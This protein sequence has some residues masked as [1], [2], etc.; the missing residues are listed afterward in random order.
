MLVLG[1]CLLRLLKMLQSVA[2]CAAAKATARDIRKY[3]GRWRREKSSDV[4]GDLGVI[5]EKCANVKTDIKKA[6][7]EVVALWRPK[8]ATP[9]SFN[10]SDF[11][12]LTRFL[13]FMGAGGVGRYGRTH[14]ICQ[15]TANADALF[16][17]A[18][19][20]NDNFFNFLES[21]LDVGELCRGPVKKPDRA[22]QKVAR[23]YYY[24][25]RHLTDLVRCCV[26]CEYIRDVRRLLDQIFELCSIFGEEASGNVERNDTQNEDE[27]ALLGGGHDGNSQPTFT[28]G[29]KWKNVG[30]IKPEG[31]RELSNFK[32][33][34]AL[35]LKREFT[36]DEWIEFGV[37]DLGEEDF[38]KSGSSY[39]KPAAKVF[40]LC[41]I[42][43]DFT[44]EGLGYRFIC[45][46]LEVGWTIES[47]SGDK[48]QFVTVKDFDKQHVRTHIC[49]VQILL[50]STYELLKIG[51]CHGNFIKARNMLSQ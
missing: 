2:K 16:E 45:L 22:F 47:E 1:L 12:L 15:V 34:T 46:N 14:K 28:L 37:E 24:D 35:A 36:S 43:D 20:L 18:A 48:L 29:S 4:D 3:E 5:M 31:G 26:V 17:E 41:K 42:K 6:K 13:C 8:D 19:V 44:R 32:L 10:T 21:N 30:A 7:L 39:F 49:E 27:E 50:K 25:P 23:K 33:A 9:F 40:K 11:S 38:I 51:G